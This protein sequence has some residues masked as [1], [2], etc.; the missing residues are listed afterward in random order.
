MRKFS[1]SVPVAAMIEKQGKN[2]TTAKIFKNVCKMLFVTITILSPNLF[3]CDFC[4]K[5]I[6][7]TRTIIET[8][9]MTKVTFLQ[10]SVDSF[11]FK[12]LSTLL[13]CS[14]YVTLRHHVDV[15]TSLS[16]PYMANCAKVY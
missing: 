16:L 1:A 4:F 14:T 9:H 6:A 5:I 3:L 11:L 7:D 2:V 10:L 15:K 12:Y 13:F 8:F